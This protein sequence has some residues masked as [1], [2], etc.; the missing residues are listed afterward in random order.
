[1]PRSTPKPRRPMTRPQRPPQPRKMQMKP[2]RKPPV[3]AH[4]RRTP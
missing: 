4:A 2:Q 3:T 1:M